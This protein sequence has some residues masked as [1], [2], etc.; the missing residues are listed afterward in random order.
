MKEGDKICR[1]QNGLLTICCPPQSNPR[2]SVLSPILSPAAWAQ[3][4]ASAILICVIC[5]VFNGS[6]SRRASLNS[7]KLFD[8]FLSLFLFLFLSSVSNVSNKSASGL[9]SL[10]LLLLLLPAALLL[11]LTSNMV[12]ISTTTSKSNA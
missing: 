1:I 6:I 11:L 12:V 9:D 7:A 8:L 10:L 2:I 3:Y 5:D 4:F